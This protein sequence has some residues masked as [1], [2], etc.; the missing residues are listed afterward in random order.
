MAAFIEW[1]ILCVQLV[2]ELV[3][4]Y[5]ILLFGRAP[6]GRAIRD[7]ASLRSS[8]FAPDCSRWSH[9]YYPSRGVGASGS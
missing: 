8:A 7:S 2:L 9:H 6:S 1:N 3:D 5:Q 4:V